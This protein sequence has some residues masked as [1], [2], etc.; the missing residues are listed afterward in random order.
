MKEVPH[1]EA[2]LKEIIHEGRFVRY[3]RKGRWEYCERTN[4]TGL[5]II[6]AMTDNHE[7]IFVEQFRPPVNNKVIEFPA[8]L[9]NDKYEGVDES[10]EDAAKR[11]LLEETGFE[12]GSID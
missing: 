8:G 6:I 2:Q 12:A 7:V 10:L 3:V 5:V 1:A 9:V 4:C 11:E